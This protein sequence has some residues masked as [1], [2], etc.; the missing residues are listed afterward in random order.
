MP[1]RS[2]AALC[3]AALLIT[4]PAITAAA[5]PA[6]RAAA[7]AAPAAPVEATPLTPETAREFTD[8]RVAELLEEYGSPGAA[9]TVVLEGEQVATAAHGYADLAEGTPLDAEEHLFPTASVAKSFTAAAVLTLAGEG[10][11]D[12]AED[13]N[14]YLPEEAR[15]TGPTVT[16]HD[17]LTHT[18]GFAEVVERLGAEEGTPLDEVVRTAVPERLF[19]PGEYTGYSN[20]GIALA[21][22]VVQEVSGVPFE[23]YVRQ[24]VF[25]PLGMEDTSFEQLADVRADRPL[26]TSHLADGTPAG[27][28]F[29]GDV[30]AGAA[31]TTVGDMARFM[32][33][34]L[35]GGR[36]DGEQALAPGVAEA[37][38]EQH[39]GMHPET[40]GM[41]YGTYQW[42]AGEV[43]L[44][45]HSGDLAGVHTG[46]AVVP[47]LDAGVFVA[48][49]GDDA[50]GAN[51]LV[52]LRMAVVGAF[53]DT[54]AP[55]SLPEGEPDPD[56]DLGAYE[57]SYVTSRLAASGPA[58]L[59]AL[60]DNVT[61]RDAGDGTL[62]VSGALA[63][64]DRWLPVSEGVFA[65]E[66]GEDLLAFV[67]RDG[68]VAAIATDMNP[69]SV[70]TRTGPLGSPSL[71][72]VVA[73]AALLVLA[74]VLVPVQRS[75]NGFTLATRVL[76][77]STALAAATAAGL[78][79]YGV[80]DLNRAQVWLSEGSPALTLPMTVTA[81]LALVSA[82]FVG[83]CLVRGWLRPFSRVHLPLAALAGLALA[84]T[85]AVYGMVA[86]PF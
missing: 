24:T 6:A 22:Y 9:V 13:V 23:E 8:T 18:A 55:Q 35:D 45:G 21:G 78:L 32:E 1:G 79:V 64:D 16:L 14:A 82:V 50:A 28:A 75:G 66:N 41:G 60:F 44:I 34:L 49:N 29:I 40:T 7:P 57:G 86:L 10:R 47:G 5:A 19:A 20:Y 15:L 80:T 27:D 4:A 33:A 68:E 42:R 46:Y 11:L 37:M 51:P 70:Y 12:L 54:F 61:V 3:A 77:T 65:A 81:V 59:V 74:T 72:L 69:T 73:G 48:V 84:A 31:V 85:G 67:E 17:L 56:A 53:A 62:S 25:T 63:V 2:A 58:R 39:A 52:D 83:V 36:I 43:P 71:H 26:V 76:L 30:P 38:L